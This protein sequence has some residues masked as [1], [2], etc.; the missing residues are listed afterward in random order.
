[1]LPTVTQPC[2]ETKVDDA[3][4]RQLLT[5]RRCELEHAGLVRQLCRADRGVLPR[6]HQED[7]GDRNAHRG[8]HVVAPP[9]AYAAIPV[10]HGREHWLAVVVPVA[11]AI[12]RH[13]LKAEQVS[14]ATFRLWALVE[15][16]YAQDQRTGRRCIVRPTTVASVM[17][18]HVDVARTCRRIAR[19]L[20][21]QV[22]IQLGR[23]L[24]LEECTAARRRGSRQR[25]LSTETALTVPQA[26]RSAVHSASPTSGRAR[27]LKPHL[28]IFSLHGLA[29]EKREAAPPPLKHQGARRRRQAR[30]LASDLVK[31]V[32]WLRTERPGRLGPA[33][34][35]FITATPPWSAQDLALALGDLTLRS[36]R[37]AIHP[38]RIQTR[39]A[40]VLA[41]LLRQLDPHVDHPS[42][43]APPDTTPPQPCGRAGCDG[44]GWIE[45]DGAVTKCPDCPPAI[46]SWRPIDGGPIEDEPPF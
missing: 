2:P 9:G 15:S 8:V 26:L 32:P 33:L 39:P 4:R 25:G 28:G 10:W 34:T 44:H 1:M 6:W 37:G 7:R 46:R 17:G 31:I 12:H 3:T 11:I 42:L 40:A 13:V 41:A 14:P 16:G 36:G 43:G 35:P 18:M 38:E 45:L 21:L 5:H 22:V 24:S 20:G 27:P 30:Q 23:M 29:A 19:K